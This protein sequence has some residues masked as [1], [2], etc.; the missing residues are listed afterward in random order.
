MTQEEL[1]ARI[2]RSVEAVSALERGKSNPPIET[3]ARLADHLGVPISDLLDFDESDKAA[4]P[5]RIGLLTMIS[6]VARSLD[7]RDLEIAAAQIT[8]LANRGRR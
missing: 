7:D 6:E 4:N 5:Q 8:A 2:E 1:A 3:Y